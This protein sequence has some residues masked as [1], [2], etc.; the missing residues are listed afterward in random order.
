MSVMAHPSTRFSSWAVILQ[1]SGTSSGKEGR[2]NPPAP[3]RSHAHACEPQSPRRGVKE[4]DLL[5]LL[6]W[7]CLL[8]AGLREK[9]RWQ[10]GMTTVA[11]R[12]NNWEQG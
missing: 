1:N 9:G 4:Q 11:H 3:S 5:E 2:Q 8:G 6:C 10:V 7:S 12:L